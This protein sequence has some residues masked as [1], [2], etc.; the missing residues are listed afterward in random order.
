[1]GLLDQ[2]RTKAYGA[3]AGDAGGALPG[4]ARAR[5]ALRKAND[6]LGRPLAPEEELAERRA[7]AAGTLGAAAVS[8]SPDAAAAAAVSQRQAA[9]VVVYHLDKHKGEVAK[10]KLFLDDK[11]IPYRLLSLEGDPAALTAAKRDSKFGIPVVFI[12]GTAVGRTSEL[13]NLDRAGELDKLVWG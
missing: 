1:M 3:L 9:P 5:E 4:V 7:F 13:V 12:A 8:G 10:I 2:I 6:L 11:K